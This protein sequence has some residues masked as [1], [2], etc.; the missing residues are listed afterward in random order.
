MANSKL[1]TSSSDKNL[2]I[3]DI[4]IIGGGPGGYHAAIRASQ[5]GAK[6]ALIEKDR[7]GGTCLNRGCIPTKALYSS[8][9]LL[10]D[11][12]KKSNKFGINLSGEP[13]VDFEKVVNNKNQLI[14][15]MVGEIEQLL[16]KN[17]VKLYHGFGSILGG[18]IDS[19][20]DIGVKG[21]ETTQIKGR[22]VIIA[23]G[24]KPALIPAFN[25]DH[26]RILTS[27]DVLDGNFKVVPE[28]LLII[29]GGVIGCEFAYIF[30]QLGS[31]VV[32]L[33]YLDTILANEEKLIVKELKKKFKELNIE[34]HEN[35]NCLSI[36]NIGSQV[37]AISCSAKV[38]RDQIESAEKSNFMADYCLISIGRAKES[39]G[40]GLENTNI[41]I[42]RDQIVVDPA[43]LETYEPGIYAIG[44][45]TGGLMLAHVAS[46]EGDVAICNSLASLEGF[47]IESA[48]AVYDVVP[49]T[50]FTNPE[51]G[52]VGLREKNAR[53][54]GYKVFIGRF[55]YQ[56]LGKA[57]C[58]GE[59]EGFMMV[60]A[61]Q[62]T[63][64]ILGAS[65]IG[66]EAP[67]LIS[68]IALAINNNLTVHDITHTIHSHPT[69]SEMVLETCEDV[70]GLSIHKA[71]R[72]REPAILYK[73]I[74]PEV[75]ASYIFP[76]LNFN[77]ER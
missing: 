51:I 10:E 66:A 18:N 74:S 32:I 13:K 12:R 1:S 11:I 6:V 63:D 38:P 54:L 35:V 24:S 31:K 59:E 39:K 43:T 68:E 57:K 70:H 34:I 29:G 25:I 64:E 61:D 60:I 2:E 16:E 3:Y 40:I 9:K 36:K 15:K 56:A 33:E 28:R 7:V 49:A 73:E 50:I 20:F 75:L 52:S 41:K 69:M 71:R 55:A 42:E 17:G 48:R 53:V 21:E 46:Y 8:A 23:T 5:Y 44:D 22:R 58:Q 14:I 62:E 72:R 76:N 45:V 37:E 19:G 27:D 67:E 65:C 4:V 77:I 30:N 26:E 47:D